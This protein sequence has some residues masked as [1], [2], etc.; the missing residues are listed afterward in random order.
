MHLTSCLIFLASPAG[1]LALSKNTEKVAASRQDIYAGQSE[2]SQI[3]YLIKPFTSICDGNFCLPSS[4]YVS[5]YNGNFRRHVSMDNSIPGS[6][7]VLGPESEG[8]KLISCELK[9]IIFEQY[10]LRSTII[11]L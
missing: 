11:S 9:N 3:N 2:H 6:W 7:N 10:L 1:D 8:V 5:I 4:I